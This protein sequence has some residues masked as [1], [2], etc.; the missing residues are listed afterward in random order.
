M[1][2]YAIYINWLTVLWEFALANYL[3]LYGFQCRSQNIGET[4]KEDG[5]YHNFE[6]LKDT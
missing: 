6:I 1:Y 3:A 5:N 4:P 2:G